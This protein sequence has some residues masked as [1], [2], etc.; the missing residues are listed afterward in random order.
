ML[1]FQRQQEIL[2]YLNKNQCATVKEL[3]GVVWSSES[4]VRRD[5]KALEQK[6]LVKQVYGGVILPYQN[7][8]VPL[9]LRDTFHSAVKDSLAQAAAEY[10]YDGATILMDNS[11][12]VRRII[13]YL[14]NFHD[15]KIIT[16]NQRILNECDNSKIELYCTG[17]KFIKQNNVFVGNSAENYI[18]NIYADILFFSSQAI[19]N[20]GEISD[21]CEYETSMR[22]VMLSRAAKKIFLCDS[23]KLGN[24]KTFTLCT[25]DDVNVIICDKPLPWD[26]GV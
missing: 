14:D 2:N 10:I 7:S 9:A 1:L 13:K 21:I 8:V 15:L 16:N 6:G 20:D 19:S 22:K 24:K 17:G 12:T 11:S 23:S 18:K 4:S 26:S 3:A 5:I 25:K